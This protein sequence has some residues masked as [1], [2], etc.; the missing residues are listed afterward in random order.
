[1]HDAQGRG[2]RLRENLTLFQVVPRCSLYQTSMR[3][4]V[5]LQLA[6]TTCTAPDSV[7]VCS[8]TTDCRSARQLDMMNPYACFQLEH[9]PVRA[10]IYE[11]YLTINVPAGDNVST[12]GK[13]AVLS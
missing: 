2:T 13:G 1:M 11:K 9:I 3:L 8:I 6:P 4:A 10:R 5:S 7:I 12:K